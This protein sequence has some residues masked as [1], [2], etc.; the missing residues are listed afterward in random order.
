MAKVSMRL[1]KKERKNTSD[2]P[3]DVSEREEYPWGLRITLDSPELKNLGIDPVNTK[4][5]ATMFV[6]A[7]AKV[8]SISFDQGME[9]D[10]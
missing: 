8:T 6:D 5:C 7:E 4:V 2:Q 1:T 10:R 3:V 9:G